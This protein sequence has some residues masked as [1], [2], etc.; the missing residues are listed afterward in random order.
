[1][2]TYF[3]QFAVSPGD[4]DDG[5]VEL[6]VEV[7]P[8]GKVLLGLWPEAANGTFVSLT[9]DEAREVVEALHFAIVKVEFGAAYTAEDVE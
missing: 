1:M 4:P 9:P 6:D 7:D 5:E 8:D 2:D 3:K